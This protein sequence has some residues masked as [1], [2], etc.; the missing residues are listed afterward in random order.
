MLVGARRM[1]GTA[2]AKAERQ[3]HCMDRRPLLRL[4]RK[5]APPSLA[6]IDMAFVED[7]PPTA[8]TQC[9]LLFLA[10]HNPTLSL[11]T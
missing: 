5:L 2:S 11:A 4:G 7:T 10:N 1:L 8:S 9:A 6:V 3:Q